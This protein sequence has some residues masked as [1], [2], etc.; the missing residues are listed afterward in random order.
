MCII[1][2]GYFIFCIY[3]V[4]YALISHTNI[5]SLKIQLT[6]HYLV[7]II[8]L[9]LILYEERSMTKHKISRG[10]TNELEVSGTFN[11][12]HQSVL[13]ELFQED[14][15]FDPQDLIQVKY[16]MLRRVK[17]DNWTVTRASETYGFSRFAYYQTETGFMERGLLGLL[18]RKKG[19]QRS[20]KLTEEILTFVNDLVEEKDHSPVE[21]A[22]IVRHR[23]AIDVHPRSI[24][25]AIVRWKKKR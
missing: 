15:F 11:K 7:H 20:H 24:G 1:N 6:V 3:R 18:P 23:F 4:L 5:F 21:L 25:R 8:E 14:D 9:S 16:E 12:K 10:K 2:E 19:P 22:E 13:D 17:K